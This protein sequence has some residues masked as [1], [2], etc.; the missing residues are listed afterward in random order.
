M[1][2]LAERLEIMRDGATFSRHLGYGLALTLWTVCAQ[3]R[4]EPPGKAIENVARQLDVADASSTFADARAELAH[5]QKYARFGP[6]IAKVVRDASWNEETDVVVCQAGY[7]RNRRGSL[8]IV[9]L[10]W[11]GAVVDWASCWRPEYY[12]FEISDVDGDGICDIAM[13][14]TYLEAGDFDPGDFERVV[15]GETKV[16]YFQVYAV[17][18]ERLQPRLKAER[19]DRVNEWVQA[20]GTEALRAECRVMNA[21]MEYGLVRFVVTVKNVSDVPRS[22]PCGAI[23]GG[24]E[25]VETVY[26]LKKTLEPGDECE[27]R[28]TVRVG[29]GK[30]E[31]VTW[32]P[33]EN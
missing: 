30:S 5:W 19:A 11:R 14:V 4:A 17:E 1:N 12:H 21:P 28:Y 24:W 9:F 10:R 27:Y 22:V 33:S 16:E 20:T 29:S 15:K 25:L 26:P 8:T 23:K 32:R 13:G 3:G 18:K 7:S 2:E 31:T 6:T